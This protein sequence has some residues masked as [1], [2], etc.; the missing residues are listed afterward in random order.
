MYLQT[1]EAAQHEPLVAWKT[2]NI[3]KRDEKNLYYS[4]LTD[5]KLRPK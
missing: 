5:Q 1:V 3:H 4:H 2:N